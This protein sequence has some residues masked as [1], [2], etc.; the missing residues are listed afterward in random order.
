MIVSIH[1]PEHLPWLGFFDKVQQAD[2]FVLLDTTQFAKDDFQNRNRIRAGVAPAWITVPVY[3]RGLSQQRIAD[4]AICNDQNWPGRC[5]GL[6]RA[7]YRKAPYFAAHAPFFERVYASS[8]TKLV[9]L[10]VRL[11]G[12]LA[13]Q[14]GLTTRV[15]LASDL[16]VWEQGGTAVNL[17]ICRRVGATTYLSGE[18]GRDYLDEAAFTEHGI[19]VRYQDFRHPVYPQVGQGFFPRLS[20][21]DLLFNHGPDSA[22]ILRGAD[23]PMATARPAP[24]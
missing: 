23:W 20:A 24:A 16:D 3:T 12:Y 21:V 22:A 15:V 11:I 7:H 19:E 9:E 14:L 13:D 10:N 4:V 5:L 18:R 8:W 6:L 2:L 1:Q 17:T